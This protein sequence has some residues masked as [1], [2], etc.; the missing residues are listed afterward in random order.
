MSWK[1]KLT[2]FTLCLCLS[3]SVVACSN[4]SDKN[5]TEKQGTVKQE[6][7]KNDKEEGKTESF[8][9]MEKTPLYTNKEL[10]VTGE[11][12]SIKYKYNGVQVSKLV[13]KTE[14]AASMFESNVG[15]ELA[16]IVFDAEFENTADKDVSFYPNQATLITN[17]KEQV[18]ADIWFSEDV[19]GDFLGN[20]S[21]RGEIFYF[22]KD[23]KADDIET[24]EIRIDAPI[25]TASFE[26]IGDA[27][28]LNFKTE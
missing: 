4:N 15:D 12:G 27:V 16:V 26:S 11:T 13:L 2:T 23:S 25:D 28:T 19:G 22:L 14:E 6:E 18:D 5:N 3:L 17:T 8:N 1:N 10:N 21:K 7:K 20:V 24:M 9:G